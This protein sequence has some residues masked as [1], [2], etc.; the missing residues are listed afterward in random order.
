MS[1]SLD[2]ASYPQHEA[3]LRIFEKKLGFRPDLAAPKRFSEKLVRRILFDDDPYYSLYGTKLYANHLVKGIAPASLHFA[4]RYKVTRTLTPELFDDLPNSFVVKS[5]FGSGLNR[6]VLD[7]AATDLDE[8]CLL[9]N[10]SMPIKVNAKGVVDPNNCAIIE[11]Y[12][13]SDDGYV[14]HDLK[15]HC[16]Q[17]PVHGFHFFLQLRTGQIAGAR[18]QTFFDATFT[19]LALTFHPDKQPGTPAAIPD[20]MS[21]AVE[22]IKSISAYFDYIRV[23]LYSIRGK[24]YFGELTPFHRG[25]MSA[26]AQREWDLR[27]G[28]LWHQRSPSFQPPA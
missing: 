1:M 9:F 21:D 3:R 16:F 4:K 28:E 24:I 22:I 2:H 5:S 26:I 12:L 7:K 19:P 8:L 13:E 23:D 27:W 18:E 14:P 10:K 20:G 17:H 11:E 6:I 15:F 25:G